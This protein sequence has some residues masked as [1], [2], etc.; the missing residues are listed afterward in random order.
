LTA[1]WMDPPDNSWNEGDE[2]LV[3]VYPMRRGWSRSFITYEYLMRK[4]GT[5]DSADVGKDATLSLP[6]LVTSLIFFS[7]SSSTSRS[8]SHFVFPSDLQRFFTISTG[9]DSLS[10]IYSSGNVLLKTTNRYLA[11]SLKLPLL[12]LFSFMMEPKRYSGSNL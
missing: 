11:Q 9:Y 5:T 7:H 4:T 6:V 3:P 10:P 12:I 8:F 2:R 1:H